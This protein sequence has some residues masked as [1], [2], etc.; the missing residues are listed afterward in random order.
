MTLRL[1]P[2][3]LR[4]L[5]TMRRTIL[6][7]TIGR[8]LLTTTTRSPRPLPSPLKRSLLHRRSKNVSRRSVSSAK[9]PLFKTLPRRTP[10]LR[11]NA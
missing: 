9:L 5:G 10:G 7:L 4:L 6:F 1:P 2:P 3:P 11:K 8:L